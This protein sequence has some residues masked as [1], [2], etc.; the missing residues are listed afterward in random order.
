MF[1]LA[2]GGDPPTAA[3]AAPPPVVFSIMPGLVSDL[4]LVWAMVHDKRTLGYVHRVY[5]IAGASLLALQVIRIPIAASPA[6]A[7]V[8]NFV[9]TL[10]P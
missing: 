4:L 1:L 7:A 10:V 5:W 8:A 9:T 2:L 6:W 3:T